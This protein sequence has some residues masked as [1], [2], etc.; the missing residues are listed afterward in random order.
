MSKILVEQSTAV[1]AA[2]AAETF[3]DCMVSDCHANLSSLSCLH[4]PLQRLPTLVFTFLC[5][6]YC[7]PCS[8]QLCFSPSSGKIAFNLCLHLTLQRLPTST[9]YLLQR[10]SFEEEV[11]V[12]SLTFLCR[13]LAFKEADLVVL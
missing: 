8:C 6:D 4:F 1:I 9:L 2:K 12:S 7:H 3:V 11:L 10:F 13:D 5:R